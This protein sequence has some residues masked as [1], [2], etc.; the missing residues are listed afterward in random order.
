MSSFAGGDDVDCVAVNLRDL[1]RTP[2]ELTAGLGVPVSDALGE[3]SAA[4]RLFVID[5]ADAATEQHGE[6]FGH[7]VSAAINAGVVPVAVAA[8]EVSGPVGDILG[9]R[10]GQA[11]VPFEVPGLTD[12]DLEELQSSFPHLQQLAANPQARDLIQRPVVADLLVRAGG[13]GVPITDADA[14]LEIWEQLVRRGGRSDRGR[15][16]ARDAVMRALAM[17]SLDGQPVEQVMNTLDHEAV[18]GLRR[19]GLLRADPDRPWTP[20]PVFAHDV[21]RTYAVAQLL[22]LDERPGDRMARAGAPRWARPAARLACQTLL[23]S[24]RD[25]EPAVAADAVVELQHQFDGLTSVG[26]GPRWADVPAEALLISAWPS[27]LV[28]ATWPTILAA[29][30]SH[31]A[32]ILRLI[33]VLHRRDGA[34]IDSRVAEP[35]VQAVLDH[36]LPPALAREQRELLT[37]WLRSLVASGAPAGHPVRMALR[38]RLV[39]MCDA[40]LAELEEAERRRAADLANRTP[41]EI[42][43]DEQRRKSWPAMPVRRRRTVGPRRQLPQVLRSEEVVEQLALLGADLG[44]DGERLLRMVAEHAPYYLGP[45]VEKPQAPAGLASWN[46]GLLR[47]LTEAYYIEQPDDEDDDDGWGS[48]GFDEDGIRDH[49][50]LGLW[51]P[52]FAHY[53]GPFRILLLVDPVGGIALINKMLNVAAR[54]RAQ[55]LANLDYQAPGD[56]GD[57]KSTLNLDGTARDYVGDDHVWLWYRGTGVGPYPCMSAMQALERELDEHVKAGVPLTRLVALLLDGCESLAMPALIVG[58]LIR[59]LEHAGE[60]LDPFLAEPDVWQL[61]FR[62]AAGEHSGLAAASDD[63]AHPER[64]SWTLREAAIMLVAHG[65]EGRRRRLREL[66][67]QLQARAV[68]E[69]DQVEPPSTDPVVLAGY[70]LKKAEQLAT[71]R[72]WATALDID[73]YAAQVEPDGSVFISVTPPEEITETL[74]PSNADLARGQTAHG[75]MFKYRERSRPLTTTD[76]V[77]DLAVDLS[78]AQELLDRPPA[79]GPTSALD[80][81]AAVAAYALEAALFRDVPVDAAHLQWA[82]QTLLTVAERLPPDNDV[83]FF[84]LGA[85]RSAAR[86]L[87]LLLLPSAAPIVATLRL[88]DSAAEDRLTAALGRLASAAAREVRLFFAA[89]LDPLWAAPCGEE[90]CVHRRALALV[91]DSARDS[92]IGD[93]DQQLQ[94]SR[95]VHLEG[96]L[97]DRLG[98]L[99]GERILV[100]DLS[101]AI[102][103]VAP[104]SAVT[105]VHEAATRLLAA[106][107]SAHRRGVLARGHAHQHSASDALVAARSLLAVAS[108]DPSLLFAHIAWHAEAAWPLAE[109][110]RALGAAAEESDQLAASARQLW[111]QVMSAVLAFVESQPRLRDNRRIGDDVLAALIPRLAYDAG[112]LT[113]E[114]AGEPVRWADLASLREQ[115]ERW[116][117]YAAGRP[118]CVD[119]LI[120]SLGEAPV[121]TQATVGLPWVETLVSADATSVAQGSWSLP[122]WLREIRAHAHGSAAEVWQRIV[123]ALAVGGDQRVA[124]LA[125]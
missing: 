35:V 103:A 86:G 115:I 93:W 27:Q 107:L 13:A 122:R 87:P 84:A 67:D 88:D 62:R 92:A 117:P 100:P 39:G 43:A 72:G 101:P 42:A 20:L 63:L 71:I 28:S 68:T 79:L 46:A 66:G 77:A 69:L 26:H 31:A 37:D 55:I 73:R 40:A 56:P 1:P 78:T 59:H 98:H 33:A 89:A 106:L 111:P 22:L 16:E 125:D 94:R 108:A 10:A 123:D 64:R 32:R 60:A 11:P 81:P 96:D 80:A 4:R 30:P 110:L 7:L 70:E 18:A 51:A 104:A 65:D 109:F 95:R 29:V 58:T 49:L 21:L 119:A 124:D 48:G 3:M 82:A 91:E 83:S 47:D 24:R 118:S 52:M 6:M 74:A 121:Q 57:Y 114:L 53:R 9:Q 61:E 85:D 90:P 50:P 120:A 97:A 113:R 36:P 12:G 116:L 76:L 2:L 112:Y 8:S 45:A 23:G 54:S 99:E 15:P 19:D 5:A 75:L 34:W 44:A 25:G 105:C 17:Q 14:M 38:D 102:R 41:E